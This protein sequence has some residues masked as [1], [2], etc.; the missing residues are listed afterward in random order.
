MVNA[1]LTAQNGD[2]NAYINKYKDIAIQEMER[3]GIPASIKLAQGILESNA[4]A[5]YLAKTANNHFGIKCGD[6]WRGKKEWR[7]DDDYNVFG[8]LRKS[9][10]RVYKHPEESFIAHSE[11]LRDPRKRNRY[12]FLFKIDPTDY[13]RW[14][15]GLKKSGYATSATYD[16]KLIKIIET[17]RLFKYDRMTSGDLIAGRKGV[18]I[19]SISGMEIRRVNDVKVVFAKQ[20]DTPA[21]IALSTNTKLSRI[22]KYNENLM[23]GATALPENA[24][25]FIQKKRKNYHG[26]KKWHYVKE[27]ESMNAISQLYGIK[28]SKL[29]GRNLMPKGSEPAVGE[30]LKLRG[31]KIKASERPR[32]MNVQIGEPVVK[33]IETDREKEDFMDDEDA[34]TP[35]PPPLPGKGIEDDK[36]EEETP[37]IVQPKIDEAADLP[38]PPSLHQPLYHSV[39]KGD[40]LYNISKRY[41]TTVDSII[42]LNNLTSNTIRIGQKLR[43]H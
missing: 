12:G 15:K 18:G 26:K 10:F 23:D 37:E 31:P 13:K 7:K 43:V 17:Y 25:V 6:H 34:L 24:R 27:G 38:S 28:V 4:G 22:L 36:V 8:K 16:K 35:E 2:R 42:K 19:E 32:L 3:A 20:G 39:E 30:R 5:S 29:Y 1:L 40:T 11:F 14:A 21:D 9:C 33:P 41:G